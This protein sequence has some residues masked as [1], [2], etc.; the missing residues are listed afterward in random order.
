MKRITAIILTFVMLVLPLSAFAE[1]KT[2]SVEASVVDVVMQYIE[3]NYRFDIDNKAML[4]KVIRE[5]LD[6]EPEFYDEIL[7]A[8]L[9]SLDEHSKYYTPKE[10]DDF[11]SYVEVEIV[12]IGAYL[13]NDGEYVKVASLI[14][15][16]PAEKSGLKAND[17]IISANGTSLKNMGSEYA[18]STIRGEAGS[19]VELE[20]ERDGKKTKTTA[21]ALFED[22]I[23]YIQIASF[24]SATSSHF[25]EDMDFLIKEGAQKFIIDLRNNTG[26]VTDEALKCAG[27][28]LPDGVPLMTLKTKTQTDVITN[29]SSSGKNY[30]LAVLVNESSASASE[31]VSAALK[32]NGAAQIIG[33]TTYGKGTMQNTASLGEFGGIKLTLAEFCGPDGETINGQGVLPDIYVDNVRK[34]VEEGY[35]DTLKYENKF[36]VGDDDEQISVLKKMLIIL[37]YLSAS[38]TDGHFDMGLYNAVKNFQK[39]NGLFSYGVLDF[40]TQ[41]AINNL[42]Y[43]ASYLEDTQLNKAIEVLKEK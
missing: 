1:D 16:S 30:P 8:I 36:A 27:Y 33:K 12:G 31:I 22:N 38:N 39:D 28:F 17:R 15:D 41:M 6:K 43:D 3:D 9:S 10:Y 18:A 24:S 19:I 23:G 2:A 4:D 7:D 35:F 37:G 40:S 34:P 42:A 13:E 5:I 32:Y 14:P 11:F 26:G 29:Q 21:G 25:K 20:I